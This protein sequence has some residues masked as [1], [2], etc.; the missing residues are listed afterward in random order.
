MAG[1]RQWM[2]P[3]SSCLKEETTAQPSRNSTGSHPGQ[4]CETLVGLL[5]LFF[6]YN[7][8]RLTCLEHEKTLDLLNAHADVLGSH[9]KK[10]TQHFETLFREF[11]E[12]LRLSMFVEDYSD[13]ESTRLTRAYSAFMGC[14]EDEVKK[15]PPPWRRS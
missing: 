9:F 6:L 7:L 5:S 15:C 14:F 2:P 8:S 12:A 1:M 10:G 4:C 11:V 13:S 3:S